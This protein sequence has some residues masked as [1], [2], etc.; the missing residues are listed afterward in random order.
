MIRNL[1]L[2]PAKGGVSDNYIP[3]MNMSQKNW[4]YNKNFQVGFGAYV[5]ALQVNDPNNTNIQRTLDGIYLCPAPNF[6]YGHHI[7][8]LRTGKLIKIPKVIKI[9]IT[10]VVINSVEKWR[11]SK[12]LSH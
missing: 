5:Q 11:R 12:D 8:E 4:Y 3:H 7:T 2:F 1:N 6:Q 9:P 10:D